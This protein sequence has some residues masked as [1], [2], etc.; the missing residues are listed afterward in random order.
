MISFELKSND[1]TDINVVTSNLNYQ[2][3]LQP[4]T[5][6]WFAMRLTL[7]AETLTEVIKLQRLGFE[8]MKVQRLSSCNIQSLF[9]EYVSQNGQPGTGEGKARCI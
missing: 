6:H 5:A 9:R 3:P 8:L 2:Y 4:I 1:H 7:N